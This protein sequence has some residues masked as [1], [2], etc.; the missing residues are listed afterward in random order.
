MAGS[1]DEETLAHV[2]Q[3]RHRDEH[4]RQ[5]DGLFHPGIDDGE[6]GKKEEDKTPVGFW[7][8]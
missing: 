8:P 7:N 1:S 5:E 3:N 6:S 4:H 2:R